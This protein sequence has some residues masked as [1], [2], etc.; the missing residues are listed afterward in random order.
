MAFELNKQLKGAV[1]VIKAA[2]KDASRLKEVGVTAQEIAKAKALLEQVTDEKK[3]YA[4]E[5]SAFLDR[6]T[7]FRGARS[8]ARRLAS[9]VKR[10]I[11]LALR[12]DLDEASEVK[13]R[14]GIGSKTP[15]TNAAQSARALALA[16]L[17]KD[18][19]YS[20]AFKKRGVTAAD[21][22]RLEEL[23][24]TL[25]E[26]PERASAT[27]QSPLTELFDLVEYFR[28]AA[29]AAFGDDGVR[30]LPYRHPK[31]GGKKKAPPPA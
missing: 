18:A 24:A 28:D 22:K 19:K 27:E 31:A 13:A 26:A 14:A 4:T 21:V 29:E 6:S 17:A 11:A 7:E 2:A 9:K 15:D 25:S 10:R 5:N 3:R 16:A 20:A 30:Y 23:G 12:R 1:V 8:E